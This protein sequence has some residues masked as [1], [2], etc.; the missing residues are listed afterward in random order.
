MDGEDTEITDAQVSLNMIEAIKEL[1]VTIKKVNSFFVTLAIVI[2]ILLS[3]C[4]CG[5]TFYIVKA[6]QDSK[7][8]L[9]RQLD[10]RSE[11]LASKIMSIHQTQHVNIER[12]HS[13]EDLVH[14]ILTRK[15]KTKEPE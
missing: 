5:L 14:D 13:K 3:A 4:M 1:V 12:P 10:Q 15:G 9:A 2:P 7:H 8:E 11:E 6:G